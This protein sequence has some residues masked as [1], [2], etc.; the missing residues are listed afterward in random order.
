MVLMRGLAAMSAAVVLSVLAFGCSSGLSQTDADARCDS[1]K[2]VLADFFNDAVYASCEACYEKC[3]DDCV[4][5]ATSPISYV[6][7][8]DG[9]G[10]AGGTSTTTT[11]STTTGS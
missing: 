10:G 2:A 1:E 8:D 9:S 5:H 6:C 11:T 7:P 4:R 3:V